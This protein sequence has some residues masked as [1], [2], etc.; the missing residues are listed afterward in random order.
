MCVPK[1]DNGQSLPNA[2]ASVTT[3]SATVGMRVCKSGVCDTADNKCGYA[4]G[5]GPCTDGGVCRSGACDATDH[6]CGLLPGDGPCSSD[7]VCRAGTCDALKQTC[8]SGCMSD[9]DCPANDFCKS[10]GSCAPKLPDGAACTAENQCKSGACDDH[11]CDGLIPSGSGLSCAAAPATGGDG[12]MALVG[13]MLAA[14]GLS[15]RRRR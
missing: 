5:D 6:K 1:L 15:R 2:P 11:K 10:D 8:S 9:S 14:A 4:N 12:G 13:L 7:A 3:C